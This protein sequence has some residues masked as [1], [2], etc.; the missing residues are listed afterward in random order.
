MCVKFPSENLNS[1]SYPPHPTI[2]YTCGVTI[3]NV[4]I[5][6]FYLAQLGLAFFLMYKFFLISFI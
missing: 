3:F 6:W 5:V 1:D 2:T 4:T